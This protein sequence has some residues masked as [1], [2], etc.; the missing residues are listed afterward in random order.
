[1]KKRKCIDYGKVN[2]KNRVCITCKKE[3]NARFQACVKKT[4]RKELHIA[5]DSF[6][7]KFIKDME[8]GYSLNDPNLYNEIIN[9]LLDNCINDKL[10]LKLD[11]MKLERKI[12]VLKI[13]NLKL[14]NQI[15]F[16]LEIDLYQL[17][18]ERIALN[19]L[20]KG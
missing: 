18:K 7:S 12:N 14:K 17:K 6:D 4:Y 10:D 13:E 19:K 5:Y 2:F 9:E 11:N 3:F 20:N 8:S 15:K 16:N 1:M